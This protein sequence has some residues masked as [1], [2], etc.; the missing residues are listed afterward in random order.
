M[1]NERTFKGRAV[2]YHHHSREKHDLSLP[3][4]VEW[5]MRRAVELDVEFDAFHNASSKCQ[6]AVKSRLSTCFWIM[7]SAV[8]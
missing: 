7:A 4:N 6:K 5:A 1:R 8:T 2:F 3:E